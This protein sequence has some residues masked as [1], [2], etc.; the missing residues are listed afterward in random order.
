MKRADLHIHSIYSSAA[1]L[2]FNRFSLIGRMFMGCITELEDIFKQAKKRGLDALAVTDHNTMMAYKKAWSLAKKYKIT[3]IP[4]EEILTLK[5]EILGLGIKRE[6]KPFLSPEKT[7]RQIHNQGGAAIA[8]HP[9]WDYRLF[10]GR[11]KPLRLELIKGLDLDGIEV[12]NCLLGKNRKAVNLAEKLCLAEIGG[13]D[14]H[15]FGD[16]GQTATLFPDNCKSVED[17]IKAIKKRQTKAEGKRNSFI[18][19]AL[20]RLRG[21]LI[22]KGRVRELL[23]R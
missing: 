18:M 4:G 2:K 6:I 11:F 13:S 17:Y 20:D 5:G 9:F 19:L 7:I 15:W 21:G 23:A 10:N 3:L 22:R 8:C 1:A 14:A 16:V 12:F